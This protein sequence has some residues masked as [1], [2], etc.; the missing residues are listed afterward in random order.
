MAPDTIPSSPPPLYSSEPTL[1]SSPLPTLKPK[2]PPP[3]TPRSFK[4]F[5]TPRSS[6]NSFKTKD[7]GRSRHALSD[8]TTPAL[9][10]FG[11]AF[12][13]TPNSPEED[14]SKQILA[15]AATPNKKR[16][17]SFC[18]SSSP[19]QSSP[20]RRVRISSTVHVDAEKPDVEEPERTTECV[21]VEPEDEPK[22][23]VPVDLR[24]SKTLQAASSVFLR[25]LSSRTA[26]LTLRASCATSW[27]DETANF[28]S[29]PKDVH[30]C[31]HEDRLALP[32]C[33]ASCHTNS[34]V[35]V[36][37]EEGSIRLLDSSKTHE[38]GFS[39]A[40]LSFQPHMN[41]IMD[42]EF[43]SDDKLLAT[44]SGDQTSRIIDMLT[45]TSI[46][47]LAKHT[48]S[49]KKVQFQPASNDKVVATCSRDGSVNIWDLRCKSS[50]RPSLH[51]QCSL[52]SEATE[53]SSRRQSPARMK[54]AQ[55]VNN[56][57]GAHVEKP[58]IK[59]G[60]EAEPLAR[61]DDISVT[62]IAFLNPGREHMFV[63]CSESNACIRLWDV[64][65]TYT[66][67]RKTAVPLAVTKQPDSHV[68]YRQFGLTSMVFNT[69]GSR[70]YSLCRDGSIYAYSTSHLILGS[71][72]EMSTSQSSYRR[73]PAEEPKAGL[74]PL[75]GFRHP[76]LQV[77]T[78]FIKMALRR[79]AN[80]QTEMLAVGSSDNCAILFPTDERYLS[81]PAGAGSGGQSRDTSR[82]PIPTG[83]T[84]RRIGL[85]R[86]NSGMG[87]SE[88]LEHTIP[89]YNHGTPLIMGHRKEVSA[90]SWTNHGELVTVSD[91]LHA[92][93]WRE[94]PDA[95]DLRLGG[96]SEGRRWQCGWAD[97]DA[98][99]D[100]DEV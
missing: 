30:E 76:R 66:S 54:Y 10:R 31:L 25:N 49:I 2:R 24:R 42:L 17:L 40:Y 46:Y 62:S 75:Y 37:D 22:P 4:R 83:F 65:T 8:I 63:T 38:P 68:K 20:L 43:S 93:C 3:I 18:S 85:R 74:G 26:R 70:L 71:S 91:D 19:L 53:S 48:S 87:L 5:F 86:V 1:P 95:R 96:E 7:N 14:D 35:A 80:N 13:R 99:Y 90:V 94:G 88:R 32:F 81:S 72:P 67:R 47:C 9:N 57:R 27:R 77:S 52:A 79:A 89:I 41:S 73:F 12:P 58:R 36:G 21:Q 92:R 45:Q 51:L 56:I 6:L 97:V 16:K 59:A 50:E 64:R 60:S 11:P 98:S 33:T 82:P 39:E 55:V 28:Y 100:E 78:F 34:L 44:A 84:G 61:R 29:R 23:T 15:P 69:D